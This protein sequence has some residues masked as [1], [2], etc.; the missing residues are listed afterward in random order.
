MS[1]RDSSRI[2]VLSMPSIWMVGDQPHPSSMEPLSIILLTHGLSACLPDCLSVCLPVCLSL[3]LSV[4]LGM[5]ATL[6][7]ILKA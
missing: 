1:L 6:Q 4:L 3:C 2:S 5:C 7:N